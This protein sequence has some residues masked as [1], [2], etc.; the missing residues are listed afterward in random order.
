MR[1]ALTVDPIIPVPPR[2]YGGIERVVDLLARGLTAR[3]HTVTVLA[4][5]AS[6]TAGEL[7]PYGVP[8]H[9]GARARSLELWQVGAFL[10]RQHRRFDVVHSF[11]RLAAIA[12]ILPL[13]RL[14]KVQSYQRDVVPWRSVRVAT[15]LGGRSV[16][17]TGCSA[18]VYRERARFG[19]EGS[20]W[21]TVFNG[22]DVDRYRA[23]AA[24]APDAPLVFLGRLEWYKGAHHAIAIARAAGRRLVIAGPRKTDGEG[25]AYFA[26]RIA[27]HI[28]DAQVRYIG[29]IDDAAKNE[30]LGRAAAL[31][32]PI[33]WEEPFGI[34]MAEA[35]ACGTPVIGFPRG[36]VPEV[37]RDGVTGFLC[38]DVGAA[39]AAVAR[40]DAIDRTTVRAACV[41]RFGAPAIVSAYEALYRELEGDT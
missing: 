31:L 8:P 9:R 4:H 40:L 36:S 14:A 29:E 19:A 12:P 38:P 5:P 17:F 11:G 33:E 20:V 22:V 39:A 10:A 7:V 27:P 6:H 34:V 23:T 26:T 35:M 21:H 25:P 13:R 3:G 16:R 15:R 18:S 37:V 30:L 41:D 1:V 32:M 28:D 2:L 24:V